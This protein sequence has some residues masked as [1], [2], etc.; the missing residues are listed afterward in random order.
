MTSYTFSFNVSIQCTILKETSS[1]CR[2]PCSITF[3][4]F[5]LN[6]FLPVGHFFLCSLHK[7][8]GNYIPRFSSHRCVAAWGCF[9]SL[10]FLSF[11]FCLVNY[12]LHG[13]WKSFKES[14]CYWWLLF[15]ALATQVPS[16]SFKERKKQTQAAIKKNEWVYLEAKLQGRQHCMGDLGSREVSL[17]ALHNLWG[18]PVI[19]PGGGRDMGSFL[20]VW[21]TDTHLGLLHGSRLSTF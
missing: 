8:F 6:N 2:K 20:F 16:V 17:R 9:L 14:Q 12:V 15:R 13:F 21:W 5:S 1:I 3:A 11:Y 19:D 7:M 18:L 10:F 4:T